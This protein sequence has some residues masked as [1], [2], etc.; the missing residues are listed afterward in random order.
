VY[1]GEPPQE[2]GFH[3]WG[4]YGLAVACVVI[5]G[6][7]L[8]I[9]PGQKDG[10]PAP[11]PGAASDP[12]SVIAQPVP[13]LIHRNPLPVAQVIIV[14]TLIGQPA[15]PNDAPF[16]NGRHLRVPAAALHFTGTV[17]GLAPDAEIRRQTHVAE[18]ITGG[19]VS[20][21]YM[22]M[23]RI[24]AAYPDHGGYHTTIAAVTDGHIPQ[25]G[26]TVD[27]TSRYQDPA[28]PCHFIPWTVAPPVTPQAPAQ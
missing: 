21:T 25:P 23:P 12:A 27:L 13:N 22:P 1:D 17:I 10:T 24:L 8:L 4:P 9:P 11:T 2:N 15:I 16:C 5:A 26:E 18:M 20:P 19:I 14:Q 7:L 3:K 6:A 28:D